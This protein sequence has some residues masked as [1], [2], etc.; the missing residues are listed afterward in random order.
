MHA[1]DND[2]SLPT[3]GVH[4]EALSVP[5]DPPSKQPTYEPYS[6]NPAEVEPPYKPYDGI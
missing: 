5:S 6:K 2:D 3:T 1:K 4:P